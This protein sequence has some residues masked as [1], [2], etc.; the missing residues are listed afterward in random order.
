MSKL[1]G[2]RTG[3]HPPIDQPGGTRCKSSSAI[4]FFGVD[5]VKNVLRRTVTSE[6]AVIFDFSLRLGNLLSLTI[7]PC[8][9]K[10]LVHLR[11]I[12]EHVCSRKP[13]CQVLCLGFLDLGHEAQLD[14]EQA[15]QW[16][17]VS[18]WHGLGCWLPKEVLV[19][20]GH[21]KKWVHWLF[22]WF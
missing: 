3:S 15:G 21:M 12:F 16:E 14:L 22:I 10:I 5:I 4:D 2:L 20:F 1:T 11:C 9:G 6:L 13:G 8:F 17:L 19:K 7:R 18:G